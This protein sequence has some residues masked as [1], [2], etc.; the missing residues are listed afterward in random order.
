MVLLIPASKGVQSFEI[1][2]S[3]NPSTLASAKSELEF[4]Y[5]TYQI[6]MHEQGADI[7][8]CAT[9]H[10]SSVAWRRI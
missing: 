2:V 9:G 8:M 4:S 5:L 6:N 3:A 10:F 1:L 7:S